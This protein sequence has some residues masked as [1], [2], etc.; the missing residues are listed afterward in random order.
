MF[1]CWA[2]KLPSFLAWSILTSF[3]SA[4]PT[5]PPPPSSNV[6]REASEQVRELLLRL[7][8]VNYSTVL[9]VVK[10]EEWEVPFRPRNRECSQCK[11]D[12][13]CLG[14]KKILWSSYLGGRATHTHYIHIQSWPKTFVISCVISPLRQPRTSFFG[15]LCMTPSTP[16]SAKSTEIASGRHLWM[17]PWNYETSEVFDSERNKLSCILSW[18]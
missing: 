13:I 15:Q 10:S 9:L 1:L 6:F 17:V 7:R 18:V 5:G 2:R 11:I 14:L 16:M 3:P 8:L 4:P 12:S